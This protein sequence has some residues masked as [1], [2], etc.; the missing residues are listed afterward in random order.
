MR[1][2]IRRI[3]LETGIT[4]V[5]VTH[6]QVEAM[7]MCD[8]IAIMSK[9]EIIQIATPDDMYREPRTQFVAGFLGNPPIAFVPGSI[10]ENSVVLDAAGVRLPAPL[11]R[12]A[13]DQAVVVGIPPEHLGPNGDVAIRGRISFVEN[14]GR[15]TLYDLALPNGNVLRS[16]QPARSDVSIDDEVEW[17]IDSRRILVFDAEGRRL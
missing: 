10:Q 6:D 15:E 14:Q 4:A 16:I 2:E 7:S 17:F 12:A 3:Q 8:R 1:S 9:G 13:D 11:A 5:L